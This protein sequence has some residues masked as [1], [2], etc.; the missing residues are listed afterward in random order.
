MSSEKIGLVLSHIFVRQG[1]EYKFDWVESALKKYKELNINFFIVL[2][3][4][5]VQPPEKLSS[6]V[7]KVFW[8]DSVMENQ[9][10]RGHPYFSLEGFKMC[11]EASCKM[12]LK[13]RAYDYVTSK[14][15]LDNNLVVSEQTSLSC[16]IIGDL[17]LYGNTKYL[18]QWWSKNPWDYSVNGLTNLYRNMPDDFLKQ[19]VFKNPEELGWKTFEDNSDCFWGHHK[20]Y[21]WYGGDGIK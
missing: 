8:R 11:D 15:F 4:H 14:D 1:E 18:L 19:A 13:N 5:G 3:G 12:T 2:S 16:K 17:F 7:D 21:E 9:L 6:L 10:G 20:N